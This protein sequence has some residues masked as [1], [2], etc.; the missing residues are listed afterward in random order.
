MTRPAP[1]LDHEP[2]RRK[3]SERQPGESYPDALSRVAGERDAALHDVARLS[4][5]SPDPD[6]LYLEA[7]LEYW[8]ARAVRLDAALRSIGNTGGSARF[9]DTTPP[10]PPIG[11]ELRGNG[12]ALWTLRADG[13]HCA[14]DGCRN[15][16]CDWDEAWDRCHNQ[17]VT[18]VL[19]GAPS[20]VT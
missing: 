19:P 18:I 8:R 7:L 15:C 5:P 13:W 10:E 2:P 12:A 3:H 9:A 16:P 1:E 6:A 4:A 20:D 14:S 11:T 17:D